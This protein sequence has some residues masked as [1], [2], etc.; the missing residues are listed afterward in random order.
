MRSKVKFILDERIVSKG[1]LQTTVIEGAEVKRKRKR[2][3]LEISK[4]IDPRRKEK[5]FS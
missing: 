5:I 2:D 1:L 4:K 3:S